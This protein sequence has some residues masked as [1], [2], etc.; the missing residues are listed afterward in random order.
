MFNLMKLE[1]QK[2]S[3]STYIKKVMLI[4]F[5][6]IISTIVP[7]YL[8]KSHNNII[9]SD[10]SVFLSN[11]PILVS[12]IFIIFSSILLSKLVIEEFKNKTIT[13]MFMY[14][15]SRKK[16]LMSKFLAVALVTFISSLGSSIFIIICLSVTSNAFN[17]IADT[18]TVTM[19]LNSLLPFLVYS[20]SASFIGL[21]PLFFGMRKKSVPTTILS[22]IIMIIFA[23]SDVKWLSFGGL[24]LLPVVLAFVGL[25]VACISIRNIENHD[26]IN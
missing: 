9:F 6:I 1:I 4:N 16:I 21:I 23:Y 19:M 11:I 17:L 2:L 12:G 14:P 26:L 20:F 25:L 18:L 5:L 24:K 22:S 8:L 3:I 13:V 10:Y 15:I 7:I